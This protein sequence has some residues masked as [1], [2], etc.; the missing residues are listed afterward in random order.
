[1][2]S[3]LFNQNTSFPR[4]GA[5]S[6]LG[7]CIVMV[8]AVVLVQQFVLGMYVGVVH[9]EYL[10]KFNNSYP[11][12]NVGRLQKDFLYDGAFFSLNTVVLTTVIF[13]FLIGI[14][15]L[16]KGARFIDYFAIKVPDF[17]SVQLW[18]FIFI[19]VL[20]AANLYALAISKPI[21]PDF[22]KQLYVSA[23]PRWLM[24]LCFI[25]LIPVLNELLFRGFILSGLEN[26]RLS[27]VGAVILTSCIW[28]GLHYN[29][30]LYMIVVTLALGVV[31]GLAKVSS[32]SILLPIGLHIFMNSIT[33]LIVLNSHN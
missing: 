5:L 18:F 19:L 33:L 25:V 20:F 8:T 14:I 6:T 4:W 17:R 12:I 21:P 11:A 3:K 16:K 27:P 10:L 24:F 22:L 23:D 32:G 31:F 29:L 26:S 13:T 2:V 7:W 30:D 15:K 1:M 28:A 9:P